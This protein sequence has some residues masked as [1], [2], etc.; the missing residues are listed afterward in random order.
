M[1]ENYCYGF[2]SRRAVPPPYFIGEMFN[3][4]D[5]QQERLE[6]ANQTRPI[7]RQRIAEILRREATDGDHGDQY[8]DGLFLAAQL[9]EAL[10][11]EGIA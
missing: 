2:R 1:L 4:I 5:D 3:L 11:N 9:V 7:E 6:K 8:R 10:T